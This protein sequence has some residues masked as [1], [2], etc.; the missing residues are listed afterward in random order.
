MSRVRGPL[1]H[2]AW[3]EIAE[4]VRIPMTQSAERDRFIL[5]R[6]G[7]RGYVSLLELSDQLNV[8][9]ATLRRDLERLQLEEKLARIRGGAVLPDAARYDFRNLQGAP[10][11]ENVNRHRAAKAAI[12][13][14]AASLCA[15]GDA[16]IIDGGSTTLQM[17]SSLEPLRLQ[18]L[19]NSLHVAS[20]LL[21]QADTRISITGGTVFRKQNILLDP[22]DNDA[23]GDF[24]A[25]RVFVSAAAVNRHGLFQNDV[26][27]VQ[28][29]RKLLSLADE[30]VALVDSSK[31]TASA[32]TV[33]CA[34]SK[35]HTLITDDGIPAECAKMVEKEGIRLIT[36]KSESSERP[37]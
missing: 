11:H 28:A 26:I 23:T 7:E 2:P 35:V 19:T 20:A 29:E 27:L 37:S 3:N 16:I 17:C 9:S 4:S 21:S 32:G 18:V 1:R 33:L 13:K 8:S 25:S 12:G 24:H 10:F 22:I 36:V 15:E 6:L 30:L 31:F 14:A 34:L 5:S